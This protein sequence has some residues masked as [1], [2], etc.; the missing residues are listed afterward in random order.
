MKKSISKRIKITR[1]GKVKRRAMA[2]C[3][4]RTNKSGTQKNRKKANRGLGINVRKLEKHL[5]V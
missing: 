4:C 5:V 1:G 2:L 3:H